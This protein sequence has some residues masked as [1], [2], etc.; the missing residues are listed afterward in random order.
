MLSCVLGSEGV[1]AGSVRSYYGNFE[2]GIHLAWV[3]W[4]IYMWFAI[5]SLQSHVVD[6]KPDAG[7]ASRNVSTTYYP[8]S[9]HTWF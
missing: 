8:E 7:M 3:K 1:C 6:N 4:A 2:L 5:M 9:P